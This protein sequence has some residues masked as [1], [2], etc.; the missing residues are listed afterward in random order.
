MQ[1]KCFHMFSR[2]A[3]RRSTAG[4]APA[5]APTSSPG[6]ANHVPKPKKNRFFVKMAEF[7]MTKIPTGIREFVLMGPLCL[8]ACVLVFFLD[9]LVPESMRSHMSGGVQ[10]ADM[11]SYRLEPVYDKETGRLKAYR[12]ISVPVTVASEKES[13]GE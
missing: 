11:L 1:L 13:V 4:V 7:Y 9:S 3:L 6:V 8:G 10:R 5:A 2:V 12:K